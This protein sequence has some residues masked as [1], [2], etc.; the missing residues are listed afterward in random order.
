MR[1][2]LL[3]LVTAVVVATGGMFGRNIADWALPPPKGGQSTE[4]LLAQAVQQANRTLPRVAA[5]GFSRLDR[6][7]LPSPK[8]MQSHYTL[9]NVDK[10]DLDLW[11]AIEEKSRAVLVKG[12]CSGSRQLTNLGVTNLYTYYAVD[13]SILGSIA[14]SQGDC[15]Q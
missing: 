9:L 14:V 5:D 2:V 11:D 3:L 4:E 13:G 7:T 1:K 15:Q 8:V 12:V 6:V 10:Q